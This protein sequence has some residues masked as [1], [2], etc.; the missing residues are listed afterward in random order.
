MP[1][2]IKRPM[3]YATKYLNTLCINTLPLNLKSEHSLVRCM[4]VKWHFCGF[5]LLAEM[6]VILLYDFIFNVSYK[7]MDRYHM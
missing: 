3:I 4:P 1:A 6:Q 5:I 2:C 7:Y